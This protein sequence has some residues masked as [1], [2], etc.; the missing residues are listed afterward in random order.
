MVW[1]IS[2]KSSQISVNYILINIIAVNI[3]IQVYSIIQ[4]EFL[5]LDTT[6][7]TRKTIVYISSSLWIQNRHIIPFTRFIISIFLSIREHCLYDGNK[8]F[9][10]HW[11]DKT[12]LY[13]FINK[14]WNWKPISM[15]KTWQIPTQTLRQMGYRIYNREEIIITESVIRWTVIHPFVW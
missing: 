15:A 7:K 2:P 13:C 14:T 8:H 6:H 5:S 11:R 9:D 4:W 12:I 10:S 3:W 1:T